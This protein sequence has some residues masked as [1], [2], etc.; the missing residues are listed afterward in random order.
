MSELTHRQAPIHARLAKPDVVA[1]MVKKLV[2]ALPENTVLPGRT[3]VSLAPPELYRP[4]LPEIAI[5]V[6][7]ESGA[8]S[9]WKKT[10]VRQR[11]SAR[12]ETTNA[13]RVLPALSAGPEQAFF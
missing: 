1:K 13:S 3:I 4:N 9:G 10:F 12:E 8:K 2:I 6:R 11:L 5:R 7:K